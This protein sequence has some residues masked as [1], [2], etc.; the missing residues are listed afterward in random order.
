MF[1]CPTILSRIFLSKFIVDSYLCSNGYENVQVRELESA[2]QAVVGLLTKAA[3]GSCSVKKMFWDVLLL[4]NLR[5]SKESNLSLE[6]DLFSWK[7]KHAVK[8]SCSVK[9]MSFYL[10]CEGVLNFDR[11][12]K[13][14]APFQN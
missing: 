1:H 13:V 14:R 3:T 12:D 9:S 7:Q 8:I 11:E 10:E 4:G 5:Y 2:T 6:K